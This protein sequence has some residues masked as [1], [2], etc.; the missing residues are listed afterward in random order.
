[1]GNS[2]NFRGSVESK[3]NYNIKK[4]KI[5]KEP[6]QYRSLYLKDHDKFFTKLCR[7]LKNMI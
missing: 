1:V 4:I 2:F 3:N 5:N 6:K 7:I